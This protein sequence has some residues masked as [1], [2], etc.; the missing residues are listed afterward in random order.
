MWLFL[1]E[2]I[3]TTDVIEV[4]NFDQVATRCKSLENI[5]MTLEKKPKQLKPKLVDNELDS[6]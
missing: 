2:C 6:S 5:I 4:I 1:Y 3:E